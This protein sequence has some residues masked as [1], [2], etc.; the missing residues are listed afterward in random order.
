MLNTHDQVVGHLVHMPYHC[1]P[2]PELYE[3]QQQQFVI[4]NPPSEFMLKEGD[5]A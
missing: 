3:S 2:V 1:S 5:I 4:P